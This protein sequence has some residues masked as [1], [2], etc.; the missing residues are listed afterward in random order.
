MIKRN[1]HLFSGLCLLVCCLTAA[2]EN[3]GSE[4][5]HELHFSSD[6]ENYAWFYAYLTSRFV[7]E[8]FKC[9]CVRVVEPFD[10]KK[11]SFVCLFACVLFTA[12][13]ENSGLEVTHELYF[14]K[15]IWKSMLSF[16]LTWLLDLNLRF[17]SI[18]A[19]M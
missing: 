2:A 8:V 18:S 5:K 7:S 11:W 14:S 4:V 15:A 9:C 19:C 12:T 3:W 17:S 16:M 6:L 1:G 10:Q 13:G